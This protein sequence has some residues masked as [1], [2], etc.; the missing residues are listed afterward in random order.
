MLCSHCLD[1]VFYGQLLRATQ[2]CITVLPY[3]LFAVIV[4]PTVINFGQ[5]DDDDDDDDI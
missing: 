1:L 2:C 4:R 5:I 3:C